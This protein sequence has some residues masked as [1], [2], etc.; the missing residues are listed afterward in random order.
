MTRGAESCCCE[1]LF[2]E[3][4][5]GRSTNGRPEFVKLQ[6]V[7]LPGDTVAVTKLDRLV[8]C[9][10]DLPNIVHELEGLSCGIAR[11]G[12][13]RHHDRLWQAGVDHHGRHWRV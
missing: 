4:G 3:K 11:G 5:L 7:L 8:R 10:R 6:K 9:S 1:R 13:V 12:L 2:S